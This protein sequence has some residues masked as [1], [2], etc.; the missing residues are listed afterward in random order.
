MITFSVFAATLI[1]QLM[2]GENLHTVWGETAVLLAGGIAYLGMMLHSGLADPGTS[3]KE[4]LIG[5]L[6]SAGMT[7]VFVLRMIHLGVTTAQ[8]IRAAVAFFVGITLL[9]FAL[10]KGLALI[11]RKRKGNTP[12]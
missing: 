1:L 2:M 4:K 5:I 3:I 9:G 7:V 11:N 12:S 10:M 8:T 6:C